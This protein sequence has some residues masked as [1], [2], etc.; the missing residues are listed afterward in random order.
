M[1]ALDELLAMFNP[2]PLGAVYTKQE[3]R[4]RFAMFKAKHPGGLDCMCYAHCEGCGQGSADEEMPEG[5]ECFA[6]AEETVYFCPKCR[7]GEA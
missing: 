4:R 7:A 2:P 6:G 3:L 1:D 5:W